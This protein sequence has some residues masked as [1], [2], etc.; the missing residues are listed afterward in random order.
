M[1]SIVMPVYNHVRYLRAA[2]ESIVS[3]EYKDWELV[4]VD[5]HSNDGCGEI[6][7]EFAA[8]DPRITVRHREVN[9]GGA[10][11]ALNDGFRLVTG[12]YETWW[13]SDNVMYPEALG[14]LVAYLD[15]HPDV[16]YVYANNEIGIM[17]ETGK[18]EVARRNLWEEVNQTWD[19]DR[20]L[21][22]GYFL[23][24]VWAWRRRLRDGV[25]EFQPEPCE[26]YDFVLR[27][28]ELGFKFAHTPECL[29][30]QRRWFGN[31]TNT[32][33]KPMNSTQFVLNKS[34]VRRGLA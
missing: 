15:T 9:G 27:A 22:Q 20:L 16:D 1:I 10:G 29:G 25:G 34:K 33:A 2:L 8:L 13:A 24:C 6:A 12:E 31:L 32:K 14:T 3:Q 23:G 4:I 21:N 17:D 18:C 7:D 30:W 28:V 26:D 5:D 19:A 11:L